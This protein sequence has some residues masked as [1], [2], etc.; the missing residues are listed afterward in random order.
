MPYLVF[1]VLILI[2]ALLVAKWLANAEPKTILKVLKWLGIPVLLTLAVYLII[3]G[4]LAWGLMLAPLVLP[5]ILRFRSA[6]RQAKNFAR[7]ASGR[8]GGG[9]TGQ[10]SEVETKFLRMTLDHDSGAMNGRVVAGP[11]SG[12]ELSTLTLPELINLLNQCLFQD[13]ESAKLLETYL[14]RAHEDWRD[15]VSPAGEAGGERSSAGGDSFSKGSRGGMTKEESYKILGL[16]PGAS[17]KE[18]KAAYHRLMAALHPDKGG[19]TYLAAKL[20][21]AKDQLL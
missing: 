14:D 10:R 9:G 12:H 1:G 6:S 15:F 2:S 17:A 5:W 18:I 8:S 4:R 3:S 7:M 11:F 13:S 16:E 19:S 20:N 21:E